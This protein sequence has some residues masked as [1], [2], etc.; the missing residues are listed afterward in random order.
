MKL[1]FVT[2]VFGARLFAFALMLSVI[3]VGDVVTVP[4]LE[5]ASSQLGRFVM[6]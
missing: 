6:E 4:V 3:V 5:E 2:Y 1:T